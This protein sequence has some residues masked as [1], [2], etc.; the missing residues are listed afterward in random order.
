[1]QK[2]IK[3]L[4]VDGLFL[5]LVAGASNAGIDTTALQTTGIDYLFTYPEDGGA[6]WAN[7]NV[8]EIV[9]PDDG[10]Y[11]DGFNTLVY[12]LTHL[13]DYAAPIHVVNLP[14][15]ADS[16]PEFG[17]IS[18]PVGMNSAVLA[19]PELIKFSF[20]PG[21]YAGNVAQFWVRDDLDVDEGTVTLV[22]TGTQSSS[23]VAA[24]LVTFGGGPGTGGPEPG[25][26][27]LLGA[28]FLGMGAFRHLRRRKI[29]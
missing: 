12:T 13:G 4:C 1:M 5:F 11:V 9:D 2:L 27:F 14:T 3:I 22:N 17:I 15:V 21:L 16:S 8:R 19:S 24:L 6:D 28:G 29:G 20:L 10:L 25:T 7:L 26:L 23:E 18:A